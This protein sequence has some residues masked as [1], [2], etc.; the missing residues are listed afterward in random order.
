MGGFGGGGYGPNGYGTGGGIPYQM[1]SLGYYLTLLTSQY[2]GSVNLQAWLTACLQVIIDAAVL[3][4]E[5]VPAFDIDLAI[6]P[7]LDILG[8]LVGVGR[9]VSFQPS[10]GVSP[11]LDDRTFRVLIKAK[12]A[13]NQWDGTLSS[14]Y[15]VWASLFP[16]GKITVV[17]NQDM[18]AFVSLS[19]SFTSILQDLIQNGYV[20]PRPE[21][22]LYNIGFGGL[23]MLG[24]DRDDAFVAGLDAGKFI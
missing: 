7:Q 4:G 1:P 5:L 3:T 18:T 21:G 12:I 19:G 13:Q 2:R 8:Q 17:D 10:N 24:F 16:G 6:G 15:T 20:V 23:P 22:V 11:V 14:L 9:G